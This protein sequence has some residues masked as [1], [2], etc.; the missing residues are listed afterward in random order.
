VAQRATSKIAVVYVVHNPDK[1]KHL[2]GSA[3][4]S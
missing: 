4:E 3:V 1:L 2:P